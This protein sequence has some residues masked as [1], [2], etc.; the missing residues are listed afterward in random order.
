MSDMFLTKDELATLTGRKLKSYQIEALRRMGVP[1]FIN[2]IGHPIVARTAIEG[3]SNVSPSPP[4]KEWEPRVFREMRE[5]EEREA[6]LR[7]NLGLMGKAQARPDSSDTCSND[8]S[9]PSA[10]QSPE[11]LRG[12][13]APVTQSQKSG[14]RRG[15]RKTGR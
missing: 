9:G 6:Q 1:F 12:R 8:V 15:P 3:G 7:R 11:N 13:R 10:S 5:K 2:A 14:H 4:V